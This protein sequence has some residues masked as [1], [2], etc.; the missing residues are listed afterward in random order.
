MLACKL[1]FD[2]EQ[3]TYIVSKFLPTKYLLIIKGYRVTVW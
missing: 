1:N 3:D 2:E